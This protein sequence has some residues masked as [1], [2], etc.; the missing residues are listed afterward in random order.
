MLGYMALDDTRIGPAGEVLAAN[1]KRI[2][3]AQRLGYAELSRLLT[4]IGRQI[5]E[6]GLRRIEKGERRVDYDDLLAL[7]YV[8]KVCPVDLMVSMDAS[9]D[10]SYP[11]VPERE[12]RTGSVREWIAGATVILVPFTPPERIFSDP[13]TVVFDALQWMPRARRADVLRQVLHMEEEDL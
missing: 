7:A 5:P 10:E 2:R 1:I 9:D 12:F 6:L 3:T 4:D 11:V 8:L 13:A